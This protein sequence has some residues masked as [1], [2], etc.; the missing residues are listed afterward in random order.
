MTAT[1]R[2]PAGRI[3]APSLRCVLLAQAAGPWEYARAG[4]AGDG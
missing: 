3:Y 2:R 1:T 4:Q